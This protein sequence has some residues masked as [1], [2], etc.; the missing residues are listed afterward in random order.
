MEIEIDDLSSPDIIDLIE[1]HHVDMNIHS[2]PESVHALDIPELKSSALTFWSARV[3]GVL[4]GCGAIKEI[5]SQCG[6]VK[7][8][9]TARGFL[10]QSIAKTLLIKIIEV[11]INRGYSVIKLETGSM[12]AFQPAR[13]LY[14]NF[15]FIECAP[16]ADYE[17]DPNSVFMLKLL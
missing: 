17:E 16:F 9:R 13:R 7:S 15:G 4:A 12:E 11:A 1:E 3:D 14:E 5:D 8:M 2:P 6:E 10:R